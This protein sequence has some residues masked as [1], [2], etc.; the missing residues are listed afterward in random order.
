MAKPN[1]LLVDADLNSL[2]MLEVSLRKAGY[3]VAACSDAS[4]ALDVLKLSKPDLILSDTRLPG[5]DGFGLVDEIRSSD[6]FADV[7]LIFLSSDVSVESKVRGLELGIEDYLTKPIYIKEIIARVNLV[8]Q[9]KQRE[10]LEARSGRTRFTGS[11]ADMGLVDLFQTIENTKKSGVLYLSSGAQK[12][13][14]YF[15][16]G[17]LID[18]EVGPL[19]A[20]RAV[21]RMLIWSEGTFEVDFRGVRRDTVIRGSTQALLMEGMRRLD[22][23]G[24]LLEQLPELGRVFEVNDEELIDRL[25][26]IPDEINAILKH[27]DGVKSLLEVVDAAGM[28]DLEA[29]TAISKLYFEGLIFD[30][31]R[32]DS[33]QRAETGHRE[34]RVPFQDGEVSAPNNAETTPPPPSEP[35]EVPVRTLPPARPTMD[36]VVPGDG[37]ES[38][39]RGEEDEELPSVPPAATAERH[40]VPAMPAQQT[41]PVAAAGAV[42]NDDIRSTLDYDETGASQPGTMARETESMAPRGRR[43]RR[44]KR[45]SLATAPGMLSSVQPP[46]GPEGAAPVEL[47]APA[48]RHD[49]EHPSAPGAASPRAGHDAENL[50]SKRGT[51]P[52]PAGSIVPPPPPT[53][54]PAPRPVRIEGFPATT[55][56]AVAPPPPPPAGSTRDS[57]VDVHERP[58]AAPKADATLLEIGRPESVPMPPPPSKTPASARADANGRHT[59]GASAAG[60]AGKQ[61][62]EDDATPIKLAIDTPATK[63]NAVATEH[64]GDTAE[65]TDGDGSQ[66]VS[67]AGNAAQSEA[68]TLPPGR[69]EADIEI[70]G[71][72]NPLRTAGWVALILVAA[73]AVIRAASDPSEPTDVPA[74]GAPSTT[75]PSRV[76]AAPSPGEPQQLP[77]Q[78]EAAEAATGNEDEARATRDAATPAEP[79]AEPQ[80][81]MAGDEPEAEGDPTGDDEGEAQGLA[82]TALSA[83]GKAALTQAQQL[84][85][86]GKRKQALALYEQLAA[87]EPDSSL[88]IGRLGFAYLNRGQNKPAIEKARRAIALDD[89]NSEAWIVLGAAQHALGQRAEARQAYLSCV[90]LG[91]GEYVVECR[92][93]LR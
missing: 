56:R 88:A 16:D 65:A 22:E 17:N 33:E 35:P 63:P 20:E 91:K 50:Q 79:E 64:G 38:G 75:E 85:R 18:A 46:H 70:P 61:L 73:A 92:R 42:A 74:A 2:R 14:I 12:G 58:T 57:D 39:A 8:L 34:S 55:M 82:G 3:S 44:R 76:E 19:R 10:G 29:L 47:E 60:D 51:L 28:D 89:S 90:K 77:P 7:P 45:L 62:K 26:E 36:T 66:L 13:A 83:E 23:W 59:A 27:F 54:P 9:R 41:P 1:L 52:P 93:M 72:R 6:D 67:M 81:E 84:D 49:A 86:A 37:A 68:A 32:S 11:L 15:R 71:S 40:T 78:P 87:R 31:G 43:R 80:N 53:P 69:R 48:S 25:A 4:S 24:R 21:Y 5:M 30:T